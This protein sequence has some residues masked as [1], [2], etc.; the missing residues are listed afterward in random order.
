MPKKGNK[1]SALK[2]GH[3]RFP[4]KTLF[5]PLSDNTTGFHGTYLDMTPGNLGIRP[6]YQQGVYRRWRFCKPLRVRTWTDVVSTITFTTNQA[7]ATNN[8]VANQ[9]ISHAVGFL[10]ANDATTSGAFTS[11]ADIVELYVADSGPSQHMGS[12]TV[13]LRNLSE[14]K[15][16]PWAY[17]GVGGT[18]N[19]AGSTIIGSLQF[20]MTF[21]QGFPAGY[22]VGLWCMISGEIEF[23][24]PNVY[25]FNLV[26][27][28]VGPLVREVVDDD[29]KSAVVVSSAPAV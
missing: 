1:G 13:P 28:I 22:P 27:R 5:Q 3:I 9:G 12:L 7:V 15:P 16:E 11:L 19:F 2:D 29:E 14:A 26:P 4:F 17:T 18:S 24:E 25:G 6:S 20:G 10:G 21:A 8:T 23:C